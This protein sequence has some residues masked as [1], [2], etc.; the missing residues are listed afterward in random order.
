MI[1][2][3]LLASF[4]AFTACN[5]STEPSDKPKDSRVNSRDSITDP[6]E[7]S[8]IDG[9]V[10]NSKARLGEAQAFTYCKCFMLQAKAKFGTI[11]ST[12]LSNLE[13]DTAQV[14]KM[15]KACE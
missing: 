8:F 13:K 6:A 11:D 9:C 5:N 10:E 14:A 1:K 3:F 2:L 15:A 4:F 12:T 7:L